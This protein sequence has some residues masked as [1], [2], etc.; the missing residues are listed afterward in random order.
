MLICPS[1][2]SSQLLCV[3]LFKCHFALFCWCS[4]GVYPV[5]FWVWWAF[6]DHYFE[7]Y[8]VACLSSCSSFAKVLS[9]FNTTVVYSTFPAFFLLLFACFHTS[10]KSA[11]SYIL[12]GVALQ[13]SCGAQKCNP[14]WSPE[15]DSQGVVSYVRSISL[16]VLAGPKLLLECAAQSGQMSVPWSEYP[17]NLTSLRAKVSYSLWTWSECSFSLLLLFSLCPH[18]LA[19]ILLMHKNHRG[20]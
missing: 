16:P 11:S 2:S 13:M 5:F 8:Q 4:H 7:L 14:C 10:G 20:I 19:F 18:L 6:C 12:E 3:F 1:T 15:P 17:N 9:C